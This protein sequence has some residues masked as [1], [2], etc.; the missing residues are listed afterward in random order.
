MESRGTTWH[1]LFRAPKPA[2]QLRNAL[3]L[4]KSSLPEICSTPPPHKNTE[5][6]EERVK[7][8]FSTLLLTD[9]SAS[10]DVFFL[11]KSFP[12]PHLPD[13]DA[14]QPHLQPFPPTHSEQI[15]LLLLPSRVNHRHHQPTSLRVCKSNSHLFCHPFV[16][17]C[18]KQCNFLFGCVSW[19]GSGRAQ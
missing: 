9:R 16:P 6:E 10:S 5:I 4:T 17:L 1:N 19:P 11:R 13:R 7:R 8:Y 12:F 15:L 3:S 14:F 18:C 2:N